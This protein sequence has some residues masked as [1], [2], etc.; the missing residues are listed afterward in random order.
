MVVFV[1][2]RMLVSRFRD[3]VTISLS[4]SWNVDKFATEN[5][6]GIGV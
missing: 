1:L 4:N 2:S 3:T 6:V 5:G